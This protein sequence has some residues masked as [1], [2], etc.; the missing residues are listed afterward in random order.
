MDFERGRI[1]GLREGGFSY[2]AKGAHM[3]WNSFTVM[4][5]WKQW[6]DEHQAA[7][8]TAVDDGRGRQSV[9]MDTCP[10]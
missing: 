3:Q 1:I 6:T 8:K 7:R 9:T 10:A 4:R 2:R 5:V